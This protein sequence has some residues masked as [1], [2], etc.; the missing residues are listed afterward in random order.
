ME[1]FTRKPLFSS[2]QF[3]GDHYCKLVVDQYLPNQA[4]VS[5]Y[6]HVKMESRAFITYQAITVKE[7]YLEHFGN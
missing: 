4:S 5:I 6:I 1:K 7:I 2:T 3:L